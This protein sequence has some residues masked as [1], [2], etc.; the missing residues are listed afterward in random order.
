MA[1]PRSFIDEVKRSADPVRVIGEVVELK[2]R[3]TRW[4]GLCPFHQEKTPSFTVSPSK[5]FYHCFGCGAHGNA[6]DFVQQI[7]G[8]TFPDA[9]EYLAGKAG[10]TIRRE[11][12]NPVKQKQKVDGFGALERATV[13][14]ERG[15]KGEALDYLYNR[16]LSKETINT[17]RLGYAPDEW[18]ELKTA[19][20]AESYN[21]KIMLDTG[22]IRTSDKGGEPYD[23]F[24]GRVM[25]P[26][27]DMQGRPVAFGGLVYLISLDELEKWE[28][29][30]VEGLDGLLQSEHVWVERCARITPVDLLLPEIKSL[31]S[32]AGELVS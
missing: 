29:R 23:T 3:G 14:F 19:L 4:V 17:F 22:L 20:T 28:F 18:R 30:D 2:K 1:W 31:D 24:R 16:G 32:I 27:Q 25:F 11:K 6:F 26:I 15:L 12:A 21:D 10:V 8:L 5:Q 9:V 7:Q 13:H